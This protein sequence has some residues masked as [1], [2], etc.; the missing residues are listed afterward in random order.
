MSEGT[1][2]DI[3]DRIDKAYALRTFVDSSAVYI[4]VVDDM[5]DELLM[6]N[7]YYARNLGVSAARMEG[8][9]CWE[10]VAG[11]DGGRCGFCPRRMEPGGNQGAMQRSFGF[12]P[13]TVEALDPVQEPV[14]V[15]ALNPTLGIWG[16]WTCQSVTW[17]GG[18]PAHIITIVDISEEKILR[19]ELSRI[20][21][22]DSR[23]GI[24]N[25]AKLEKDLAERTAGNY[26]LIAFD[27]I[28][29]R[30]MNE[31]YGR[32][33]IDALLDAVVG[34][35]GSF[36]LQ[37]YG[38]YRLDS[39][40]FCLLLDN[41]DMLSASGLADRIRERFRE[42]WEIGVSSGRVAISC[43]IAICVIDG[44]LGSGGAWDVLGVIDRTLDIAKET[45]NIAVYDKDLDAML[46]HDL[47]LEHSLKNC[48]Q[49]DMTGFD[50]YFQPIVDP[51]QRKW[52]GVEALCRWV[53]PEFGRIPP[54]VFI[55][56]AE[57]IGL[58][59]KIGYW[60]LDTAVGICAR[61]GLGGVDG[62]MLDI[63]LSA[64]QMNDETLINKV[65]L[66]LKTHKFPA[67]CLLLEVAESKDLEIAGYTHTAIE[68]LKSLDIKVALDD[69]GTGYSN[70]N[71]LRSLPVRMLKTEKQFIDNIVT[72]DY[73]KF[74][75]KILVDLAHE[76]GMAL[77]SEGVETI[78][79][80]MELLK[81]GSDYLQGYL[82]AKPLSPMELAKAVNR[83][84]E[85]DGIFTHT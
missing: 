53:S 26:C 78:E 47:A 40:E 57:R 81:S 58:I 16:R 71:N 24:P 23:M 42:P 32:P 48:V 69:F 79:Q 76:A 6:V 38:I 85:P 61:L 13:V 77:V 21:Y 2:E 12:E 80:M 64:S 37:H 65:L 39:D 35:L 3:Q 41:A 74:L 56:I 11:E 7:N 45:Q 30:F 1:H 50:V 8:S 67:G 22:Y 33:A 62:F 84:Y 75:T 19:E 9:R 31:A 63:N 59:N 20:A 60:V 46:K 66:S 52:I 25:R 44:R 34:W 28:S 29:L 17:A 5:T 43:H 10:F 51:Y 70:F 82:F 68:R 15:E 55:Q 73:Q 54:L 4:Y 18:R 49:E 27:Y 36:G 72:D 14:T 83:F